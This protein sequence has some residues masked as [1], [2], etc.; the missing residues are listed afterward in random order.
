MSQVI[1]FAFQLLPKARGSRYVSAITIRQNRG[2]TSAHVRAPDLPRPG[3]LSL[4]HRKPARKKRR[5]PVTVRLPAAPART[6]AIADVD[7]QRRAGKMRPS[8]VE[9]QKVGRTPATKE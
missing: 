6:P 9:H 5:A 3:L 8:R 1:V 4:S 7:Q 2:D